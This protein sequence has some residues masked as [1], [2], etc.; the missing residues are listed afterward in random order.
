MK[1]TKIASTVLAAALV[2][3]MAAPAA[4]FA[5]SA[6]D[7]ALE[8]SATEAPENVELV[9]APGTDAASLEAQAVADGASAGS[10]EEVAY[11]SDG[12]ALPTPD[13]AAELALAAGEE[14]AL[15]PVYRLYQPANSEHLYTPDYNEALTLYASQ[16]W[17]F[18]G[19]SW[20]SPSEGTDVYRLYNPGLGYHLYTTDANEIA[21]LTSSEGWQCDNDGKPL[22]QSGGDVTVYRLYNEAL[23]GIHH[24][25]TS[26][27][28]YD[29]LATMDW[30]QEGTAFSAGTLPDTTFA[31]TRFFPQNIGE[32]FVNT[33]DGVRYLDA[34]GN[35][36]TGWVVI[37][38]D[39]DS[40]ARYYIHRS[41]RTVATG[42]FTV[43]GASYYAYADGHVA[44]GGYFQVGSD[45]YYADDEGALRSA[46]HSEALAVEIAAANGNDLY[47]CFM[48]CAAHAFV[49]VDG[50]A[51]RDLYDES[52][53]SWLDTEAVRFFT[54][55]GDCYSYAAGFCML[56][57][58]L[59]YNANAMS[60]YV[61][62]AAGGTTSHSW[63]DI[64]GLLYDPEGEA[65]L[66][67][68]T[69]YAITY[70][71]APMTYTW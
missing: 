65:E 23:G 46:T 21:V 9:A 35:V 54:E 34:D 63:V 56:A 55:G 44:C 69:W 60:G 4:A 1:H 19:L 39:K 32:G 67:D 66:P 5:A 15:V 38:P 13:E 61:P 6:Q 8:G 47:T 27:S 62:A 16:G 26:K 37:Y 14:S 58:V 3:S 25:T 24:L 53:D 68:Y 51:S 41:T 31:Y 45:W 18:E 57:R 30:T 59:G 29:V 71:N 64:D 10:E 43:D 2:A 22:Y 48:W 20:S 50:D 52:V 40:P 28:E 36:V 49:T 12:A 42:F 7:G 70:A 33:S 11:A 17:G